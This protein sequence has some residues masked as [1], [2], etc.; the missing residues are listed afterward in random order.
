MEARRAESPLVGTWR[1]SSF[2][3]ESPDGSITHPYG[4]LLTGYLFYTTDGW[5]SSAFM[6]AERTGDGSND[7]ERAGATSSYDRFMAYCGRYEVT[8]DRIVHHVEVSSLEIWIGSVQERW[9]KIDGDRLTLLTTPLTVGAG[10][11]VG[12]LT[13]QR[14]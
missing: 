6:S 1:L 5:M 11:P 8:G 13:W 9:F 4:K 10:T 7:L 2:E 14:A 12:R 3:L